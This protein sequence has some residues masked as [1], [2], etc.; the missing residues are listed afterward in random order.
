MEGYLSAASKATYVQ[1]RSEVRQFAGPEDQLTDFF[2]DFLELGRGPT[3]E[4]YIEPRAGKLQSKV[5]SDTSCRARYDCDEIKVRI[6]C[7][8]A[9]RNIQRLPA[10]APFLAPN[11]L[12]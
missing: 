9:T 3:C 10:Q 5:P 2:A 8:K 12:S 11:F 6:P 1:Q 7:E 4:E